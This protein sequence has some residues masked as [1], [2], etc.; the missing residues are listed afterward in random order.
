[1]SP[2]KALIT[3]RRL[4]N[5][6]FYETFPSNFHAKFIKI[7]YKSKKFLVQSSE[8]F[9]QIFCGSILFYRTQARDYELGT[10]DSIFRSHGTGFDPA[11][12]PIGG[13]IQRR[14]VVAPGAVARSLSRFDAAQQGTL[15]AEN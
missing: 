13:N 6:F 4:S 1:M 12:V 11:E 15:G 9:V 2:K 5:I 10:T 8:Y 7:C 3:K 14:S